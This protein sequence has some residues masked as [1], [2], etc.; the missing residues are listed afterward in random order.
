MVS[1]GGST[2]PSPNWSLRRI[3]F[4]I[5]LHPATLRML[6]FEGS[7]VKLTVTRLVWCWVDAG[8]KPVVEAARNEGENLQMSP[9][10]RVRGWARACLRT[11]GR[12]GTSGVLAPRDLRCLRAEGSAPVRRFVS[13]QDGIPSMECV[14]GS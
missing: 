9:A 14:W 11:Q 13:R 12:R 8:S 5:N 7:G 6:W 4:I 3:V 2:L 10:S 1:I